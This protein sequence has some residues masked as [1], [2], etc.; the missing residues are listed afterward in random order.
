MPFL[1]TPIGVVRNGISEPQGVIWEQ[2][3]SEV[4]VDAQWEPALEGIEAFSHIW[5]IFWLHRSE[6]PASLH[7]HPMGREDLPEVGLFAT[8]SPRRPNPIA[9]TAVRLLERRGRALV[10]RGLDALDGTPVLDI[11]PYLRGDKVVHLRVPSWP[12]K[13]GDRVKTI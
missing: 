2:V 10:V 6:P 7:I 12:S 8:R 9:I 11:K 3:T 5:V 4:V 1:C 13:L